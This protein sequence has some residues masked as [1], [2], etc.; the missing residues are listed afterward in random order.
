MVMDWAKLLS[1]K[2]LGR[3]DLPA[4]TAGRSEFQ[5]DFD[6]I[7]FS[8]AFR[9]LQDKTQVVPL[10]K[11]DYVRT[12]LTH[13]LE[14][15]CV[16]RSLGTMVGTFLHDKNLLPR[17]VIPA[18][19]GNIVASACLAHDIG[20]PPFGHSGE[21]AIRQWFAEQGKASIKKLQGA[22]KLD[23]ENFEGNA[24]GFRILTQL[25]NPQRPGLQLTCATLAAFAKYPWA[26]LL[27]N[28]IKASLNS[29]GK[30]HGYFQSEK[31]RFEEVAQ[32]VGLIRQGKNAPCWCRHPLAFLVEAADDICYLIVDFEDGFRMGSVEF[33]KFQELIEPILAREINEVR[34]E[35]AKIAKKEDQAA[36]LR[37]KT[38]NALIKEV[39]GS[40]IKNHDLILRGSFRENLIKTI[41]AWKHLS[42]IKDFS[43]REVYSARGV[44]E[45]EV[46]EFNVLGGLLHSFV[47]AVDDVAKNGLKGA[48][49]KNATIFKLIPSQFLGTGSLPSKDMYE[50]V[51]HVTDF[52]S[53]MTDSYAVGL[54]K[55]I[56]GIS[57]PSRY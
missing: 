23:F 33:Q 31:D 10:A 48:S 27:P 9:R 40:F 16:G 26:S 14:A 28:R 43:L 32:E 30:K 21:S 4:Q 37:A 53:G 35:L 42:A 13:S 22:Y 55:Q 3:S 46:P 20:N 11:S 25:Q 52:V 34:T 2:R 47:A 12:R 17:D 41:N 19:V 51:L 54:Y 15:S 45:V 5:R 36:Y 6:R 44:L 38:I 57:L 7:V 49:S 18:D 56:T 50:R 39:V 24:Q 8:S 29:T 1:S